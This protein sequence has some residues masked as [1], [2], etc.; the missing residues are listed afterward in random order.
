MKYKTTRKAVM[1]GFRTV[2]SVGYCDAQTLLIGL[3]PEAYTCG[4]YG[5]NADVY[6]IGSGIAL[7]TGY[8]PFGR[9]VIGTVRDFERRARAV[10]DDWNVPH[11]DR[12]DALEKLREE[13]VAAVTSADKE[14]WS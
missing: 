2:L 8:R 12:L 13:F 6:R 9:N 1:E 10:Y 4:V 11:G 5:W 3:E 7:V 14:A